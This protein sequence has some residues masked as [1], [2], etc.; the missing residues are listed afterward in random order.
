MAGPEGLLL[1]VGAGV[2]CLPA[3]PPHPPAMCTDPGLPRSQPVRLETAVVVSVD[4]GTAVLVSGLVQRVSGEV[5]AALGSQQGATVWA[6]ITVSGKSS[7]LCTVWLL[8]QRS[9]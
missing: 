5:R 6:A 2:R 8:W 9:F 1:A 4:L 3:T 7:D